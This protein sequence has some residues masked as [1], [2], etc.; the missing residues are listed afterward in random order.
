ML[1]D[2]KAHLEHGA[3]LAG[4]HLPA[5]LHV[6]GVISGDPFVQAAI[7][8]ALSDQGKA[9]VVDLMGRLEALEQAHAAAVQ[10]LAEAPAELPADPAAPAA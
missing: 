8:T 10:Q 4:S 5:L 7:N 6:A 2:V 3:E 1:S 9:L